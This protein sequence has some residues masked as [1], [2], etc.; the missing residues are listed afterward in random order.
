MARLS[1]RHC[2]A[3]FA[4]EA[5]ANQALCVRPVLVVSEATASALLGGRHTRT[6]GFDYHVLGSDISQKQTIAFARFREYG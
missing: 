1:L 3:W 2:T 5:L 4:R 6:V